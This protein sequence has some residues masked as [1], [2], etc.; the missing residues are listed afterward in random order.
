M[1]GQTVI[2]VAGTHGK[3]TTTA[4]IA[5]MLTALGCDPSY[6]IGGVAA[7]LG[8][9]AHAGN[10]LYFVIEA[11]EYDRIFLGLN[12]DITV[13]TNVEHDHPDCYPTFED[14]SRAFGE[15]VAR[16]K[17]EGVLLACS[18]D[19]GAARLLEDSLASGY[20]AFSYGM[21]Y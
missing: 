12:P 3:T 4:M 20:R 9:N 16:L 5:W 10:W 8:T 14:F 13:V 1:V 7:N 11:D 21:Q 18:D 2:A 15:F 17:P 19:H 6:I